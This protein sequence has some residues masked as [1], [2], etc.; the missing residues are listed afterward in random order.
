MA[1]HRGTRNRILEAAISIIETDGELGLRVDRVVEVAGYTKPVLY[2]HFA[3]REDLIVAAH[4]ERYRR[5]LDA[6]LA[7]LIG[8]IEAFNTSEAFISNLIALIGDFSSQEGRRRRRIRAEIVGSAVQHPRLHAAIIEVNRQIIE[9]VG[10]FLTEARDKG[11]ISPQ[12]DPYEL[13][14]WWLSIV[15]GRYTVEVDADR[16]N[17]SEWTSI[18]LSTVTHLLNGER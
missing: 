11:L 2:H 12:R 1:D 10:M 4:A 16:F 13:A 15:A 5:S 17:D 7:P 6:G 9:S 8:S 3:D 18:V 14:T